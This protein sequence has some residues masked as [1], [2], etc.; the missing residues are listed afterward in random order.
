MTSRD[1]VTLDQWQKDSQKQTSTAGLE[2]EI[3][4]HVLI[5]RHDFK[6]VICVVKYT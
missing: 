3:S 1:P 2:G 6:E 5:A 4:P